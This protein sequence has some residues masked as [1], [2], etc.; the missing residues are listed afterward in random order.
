MTVLQNIIPEIIDQHAEEAAFLWSLRYA[1]IAA[2]HYDLQDLANL[3]D[4]VEAHIDGLRIAGQYGFD[5]CLKNLEHYDAGEMFA[6]SILA[7]EGDCPARLG[8]IFDVA[9]NESDTL[10]GLISAFGWV[11]SSQLKGKV[12]ALLNSKSSFWRRVGISAC[13]IHRVDPGHY[14]QQAIE[15]DDVD[16]CCRAIR[17]AGEL[18]RENLRSLI[19]QIVKESDP[20]CQFWAAW[21]AVLL[22]DNDTGLAQLKYTAGQESKFQ[23]PA[24]QLA[25]RILDRSEIR[26]LIGDLARQPDSSRIA[27]IGAGLSGDPTY[28][29]W[30]IQQLEITDVAR[31]AG[32]AISLITGLDIAYQ[33]LEGEWPDGFE[34]GPTENPQDEGVDMDQDEDLPWPDPVRVAQWWDQN[35]QDF[36]PGNRY[37]LGK[38]VTEQQCSRVLTTGFQRQR[39]IAALDLTLMQRPGAILFETRAVGRCQQR[40]LA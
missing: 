22:G 17:A 13:A 34:A 19:L 35:Q 5:V 7:L 21:S 40:I 37:L 38:P 39:K 6:A 1:A 20:Q 25:M 12:N 4:R 36:H 33:D 15:D 14:L 30:L 28:I 18:G 27:V 31:V 11:E 8:K 10:P 24:L 2:P 9:E 29:P 23:V 32:E 16:L 26:V 3:D